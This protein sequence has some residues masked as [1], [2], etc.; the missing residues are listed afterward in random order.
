MLLPIRERSIDSAWRLGYPESRHG[1]GIRGEKSAASEQ[2]KDIGNRAPR[3]WFSW[4]T[5]HNWVARAAAYDEH[6]AEQDRLLWE[7]RRRHLREQDWSQ[8]EEVRGIISDAL[9]YARGF[10][11]R[12][13]TVVRRAG[14]TFTT[15]TETFDISSLVRALSD[16]SKVQRLTVNEPTENIQ[17]TG[18]ALDAYIASQLARLAN[19]GETG[20]GDGFEPDDSEA[21]EEADGDD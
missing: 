10:I 2:Q 7:E 18:A 14:Q 3:R 6:L 17:L 21:D 1:G 4:S 20:V 15:V 19:G 11:Q 9:P 13:T 12:H 16:T 8:A 5:Q